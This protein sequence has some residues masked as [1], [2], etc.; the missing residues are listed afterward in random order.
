MALSS[1]CAKEN[2]SSSE[3]P[4]QSSQQISMKMPP[5]QTPGFTPSSWAVD[6]LLQLSDFESSDKV[7]GRAISFSACLR[8]GTKVHSDI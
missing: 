4:S 1:K 6:D 7:K 5:Q 8:A 2:E 3:P